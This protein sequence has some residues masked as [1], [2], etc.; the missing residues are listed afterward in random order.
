MPELMERD[1]AGFI[2]TPNKGNLPDLSRTHWAADTG[3]FTT[4]VEFNLGKY[5]RYL[6]ARNP[7]MCLFATAPDVMGDPVAT[8]ARSESVLPEIRRRGYPAAL[9]AQDGIELAGVDWDAFDALFIGGSTG[10]KLSEPAYSIAR[11]AKRRGK[12]AHMGRVNSWRRFRAALL[13]GFD[14][15]DGTYVAFGPDVNMPDLL[16]WLDNQKR[17]PVM[18]LWQQPHV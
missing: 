5:Y 13:S 17:Q 4:T 12:W 8:W 10:W 6:E 11:E 3:C 2:L 14:S 18:S 15:V 16:Q 9:V 7:S 1:D